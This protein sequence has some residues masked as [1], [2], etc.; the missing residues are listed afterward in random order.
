[1]SHACEACDQSSVKI[2]CH[3]HDDEMT[4]VLLTVNS[5]LLSSIIITG[6]K[7]T[8]QKLAMQQI[9]PEPTLLLRITLI[10]CTGLLCSSQ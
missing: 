7:V 3:I 1:M 6:S 5:R 2:C 9:N 8:M 10:D 4:D